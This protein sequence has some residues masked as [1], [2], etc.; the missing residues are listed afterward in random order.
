MNWRKLDEQLRRFSP[1][2]RDGL[3][4]D[5]VSSNA[6]ATSLANELNQLPGQILEKVRKSDLIGPEK[7]LEELLAFQGFMD[8]C[9]QI[10]RV[11]QMVRAQVIVQN[12]VCFTY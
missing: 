6:L 11:P 9:N 5:G 8:F 3:D 12:H 10:P 4:L 7:R 2:L 1:Q